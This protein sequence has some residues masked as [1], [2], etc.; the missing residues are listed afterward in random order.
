MWMISCLT[1]SQELYVGAGL[2]FIH[3]HSVSVCFQLN[4][5]YGASLLTTGQIQDSFPGYNYLFT[6]DNKQKRKMQSCTLLK[7]EVRSF[8]PRFSC[9]GC[10]EELTGCVRLTCWFKK[11]I[12]F[13]TF[14]HW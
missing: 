13:T 5:V 3:L 7:P 8:A 1:S 10:C 6:G 14:L 11:G 12:F 4:S 9:A 2:P